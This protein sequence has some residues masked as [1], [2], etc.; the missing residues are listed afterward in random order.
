MT[1]S[2]EMAGDRGIAFYGDERQELGPQELFAEP[3]AQ[4]AVKNLEFVARVCERL[5]SESS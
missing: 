2:T 3:D 5:L 1:I 4:R